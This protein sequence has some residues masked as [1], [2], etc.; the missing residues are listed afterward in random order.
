MDFKYKMNYA[1]PRGPEG[2]LITFAAWHQYY[3]HKK[4]PNATEQKSCS[5]SWT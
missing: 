4:Y 1:P 3:R 5:K 2:I